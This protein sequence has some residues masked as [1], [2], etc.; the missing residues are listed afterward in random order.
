MNEFTE[1]HAAALEFL[2]TR[3]GNGSFTLAKGENYMHRS[4]LMDLL[5]QNVLEPVEGDEELHRINYEI[6]LDTFNKRSN[7]ITKE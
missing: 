1:K 7:G 6:Y 3:F 2:V 4:I 5:D